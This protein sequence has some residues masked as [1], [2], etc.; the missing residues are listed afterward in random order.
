MRKFLASVVFVGAM[1]PAFALANKADDTVNVAFSK[2]LESLDV[3]YNN[4]REGSLIGMAIYDGLLERNP[5]T[6]EFRPNLATDWK[7]IDD[8]TLEFKLREGVKFHNGEEFD[9]DDVVYTINYVTD[10]SNGVKTIGVVAWMES[11]EKIDKYTVR[12]HAKEPFPVALEYL[13]GPVVMYPNEYYAKVGPEGMGK[14]PVGTGPY[15]VEAVDVGKRFVLKRN[16]DYFDGPKGKASIE[17]VVIRTVPEVNTQLAELFNGKIDFLWQVPSDQAEE[18]EAKGGYQVL[19]APTFRVGYI[20]MDAVNRTMK[21]S[22]MADIRVRQAINHAI[23]R[24]GIL[25]TLVKGSSQ[26][27]NSACSPN[28]F[29][30]EQDVTIYDYDVEKAK[31]L[32]KEAGYENGFEVDFYAYRDRMLAE[33]MI[34]MLAEVGIKA[35]LNYMQYNALR[36]KRLK[37]GVPMAFLTWGSNSIADVTNSTSEFFKL[38]LEDDAQDKEVAEWLQVADTSTDPEKRKEGYTKAL[39]KIADEAYWVPLWTYSTNFA[40]SPEL[41]YEPTPDEIVRF[42]DF[43]WK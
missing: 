38:G 32:L 17:N 7:W 12:I 43:S 5:H 36:E 2:E 42:Q 20:T 34:G 6:G 1:L 41:S 40:L 33:A 9:A 39:K 37:E 25:N 29:G 11:A 14:A 30:C 26:L 19:T 8:K 23:N 4:S 22:P 10:P 16:D 28:Q 18:L 35:N 31:Q 21:D 27:I 13:A 3:F 15:K 24:E